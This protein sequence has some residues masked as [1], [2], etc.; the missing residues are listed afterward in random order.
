MISTWFIHLVELRILINYIYFMDL[1]QRFNCIPKH[2]W[3]LLKMWCIT[4][5]DM[6]TIQNCKKW[7]HYMVMG[8][9]LQTFCQECEG[10]NSRCCQR[11]SNTQ[12]IIFGGKCSFVRKLKHLCYKIKNKLSSTIQRCVENSKNQ[13][14]YNSLRKT[15]KF[16]NGFT[17]KMP[18]FNKNLPLC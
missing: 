15:W 2:D 9:S 11:K 14:Y 6:F 7:L 16:L 3:S 17:C 4:F 1:P 18:L 10:T 5:M 8:P 13:L 12:F